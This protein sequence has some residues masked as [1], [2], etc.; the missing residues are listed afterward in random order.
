MR[1]GPR[2]GAQVAE[3]VVVPGEGRLSAIVP[4]P[5]RAGAVR[6]SVDGRLR[7]TVAAA[8]VDGLPVGALLTELLTGRLEAA[9][10]AEGALRSALKA[11]T[12]RSYARR[13]L[14]RRLVRKGHPEPAVESALTECERMGLIDD[15]AFARTF[16]ETRAA[17]G[18]GPSRVARDLGA[19][20]VE[21]SIID[22]ALAQWPESAAPESQALALARKRAGQLRDVERQ[23]RRR[24]VL[25]YLARRGFTGSTAIAAVREAMGG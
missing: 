14:G 2:A 19:I 25:A 22:Q 7:W 18:R 16:V 1:W 24:R 9:A 4:D 17:R 23:V 20:G 8:A 12:Y 5:R 3:S 15:L 6:L 13:E 10:D 11:F 21:R